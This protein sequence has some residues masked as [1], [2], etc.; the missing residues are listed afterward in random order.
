MKRILLV[1]A[2]VGALGLGSASFAAPYAGGGFGYGEANSGAMFFGQFGGWNLLAPDVGL[3]GRVGVGFGTGAVFGT[4][5][6]VT[7]AAMGLV[8]ELGVTYNL[9][10]L[11]N[12]PAPVVFYAVGGPN[13]AVFFTTPSIFVA[14]VGVGGG[15]QY[16]FADRIGAFLEVKPLG[17][18]F[19]PRFL[20][21]FAASAGVNFTF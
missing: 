12:V 7:R 8:V 17:F 11:V 1:A 14:G 16:N 3:R 20:Y 4:V 15:V 2:L 19:T 5:P 6:A 18:T 10:R 13:F 9:T 21:N